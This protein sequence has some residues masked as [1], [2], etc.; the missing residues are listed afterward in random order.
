M[1]INTG[2]RDLLL[3]SERQK[4]LAEDWPRLYATIQRLGLKAEELLDAAAN[5]RSSPDATKS[6][7]KEEER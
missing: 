3:K 2:A 5:G 1:F 7:T 6:K 4:F